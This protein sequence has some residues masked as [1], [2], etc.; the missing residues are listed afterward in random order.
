[1]KCP[2]YSPGL[3]QRRMRAVIYARYSSDL[4]RDN[5]IEDQIELCRRFIEQQGWTMVR[6]YE[7]R[8]VSGASRFRPGYQQLVADLGRGLFDVVVVEALD[9]LSRKLADIADLHDRL[10][11][12]RIKLYALNIGEIG[13]MHIGMLGTMAQLFLAD[14]REKVLRGQL[15]R[16]RQGKVPGGKAY[17]YEV[18]DPGPRDNGGGF[19]VRRI[20]EGEAAIVRRIF[21]AFAGGKS[22]RA[23]AKELNEERV[24]GPDGRPW[25]DTTIR[26]QVDRATGILNNAIYVG[27]LEWNRCSYVKNPQTGK[28]VARPNPPEKW[29]R[30]D[31]PHLRIIDDELW[32]RVKAR[33]QDVRIEMGKDERGNALNRAHRRQFLL[34]GLL[35][36]GCCGG[37]Y[38]IIGKDRYGCATRRSKGTCSNGVGITRQ[39]VETRVLAGLKER[40]MAPELVETFVEEFKAELRRAG[41]NAEDRRSLLRRA[42]VD[43]DRKIAGIMKAI[44]DGNYNQTLTKRLSALEVEKAEID[45]KLAEMRTSAKIEIHPNLFEVY[46][47]KVEKLEQA[48]AAPDTQTEA[49]E[50]LRSLIDRIE[51]TPGGDQM[52]LKLCGDLATIIAFTDPQNDSGPAR[53]AR[54]RLSVV[55]GVGFEPT[56]FRL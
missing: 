56:T 39:E 40:L 45:A 31:V 32:G 41:R 53:K 33:Q 15:G 14:L 5:S 18:V 30:A 36:C 3:S 29:E 10:A 19:G 1:M 21:Q 16:V 51:L 47:R 42:L 17:G 34:S 13:A 2:S 38:T 48:L 43:V 11:F 54:P 50:V 44:E 35:V 37:A 8:A 9:R 55:A 24:P 23:I 20:N 4:Q 27:R 25:G 52:Q 12:A 49:S 6:H 26:G 46:R 28:R 7:D 22:P